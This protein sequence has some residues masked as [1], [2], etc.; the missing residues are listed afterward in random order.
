MSI[1]HVQAAAFAYQLT[2]Y[3]PLK[4]T[5]LHPATSQQH[6]GPSLIGH[7]SHSD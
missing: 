5:N 1:L 7:Q 3:H 2:I 4:R 6:S